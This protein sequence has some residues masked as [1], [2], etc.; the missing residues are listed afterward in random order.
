MGIRLA[1]SQVPG[2]QVLSEA[3]PIG[4][5]QVPPG[6]T[7]LLLLADRGTLGGY[8][9][10]ALLHPADL[11]KAGQLRTGDWIRFRVAHTASQH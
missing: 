10:P 3:S 5:L 7:P 9:K 6:G 1:G 11:P 8:A 4:A 2:G